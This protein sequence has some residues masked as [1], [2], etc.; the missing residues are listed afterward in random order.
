MEGKTA[1]RARFL[2]WRSWLSGADGYTYGTDLYQW[3]AD[4][5]KPGFW[6]KVKTLRSSRQMTCL[7]DFLASMTWWQLE[8]APDW[9]RNPPT[10]YRHP[11]AP[12]R[13]VT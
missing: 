6:R 5:R 13:R 10:G 9:I 8:P 4:V 1:L 2:G 7:H 3:E 12:A 11:A